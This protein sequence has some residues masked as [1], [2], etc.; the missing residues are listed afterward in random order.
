MQL[1]LVIF[2]RTAVQPKPTVAAGPEGI[3]L[4]DESL[5]SSLHNCVK[6]VNHMLSIVQAYYLSGNF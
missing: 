5:P 2:T 6:N 1:N 3:H 4:H